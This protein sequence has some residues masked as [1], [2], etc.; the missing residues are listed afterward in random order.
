MAEALE[1]LSTGAFI[2]DNTSLA[3][4]KECPRKYYYGILQGYRPLS[5]APP[6]TFGK[7]YHDALETYDRSKA[8]GKSHD[9]SIADAI[10]VAYSSSDGDAT[11]T[12]DSRRSRNSLI[13]AIVWYAEQYQN[14]IMETIIL[15]N[16]KP[17]V[18]LSFRVELPFAFSSSDDPVFYCGHIDRVVK[19]NE[20]LYAC[21]HKHTVSAFYDSYWDR[22]TF[23]S[24]ISGYVMALKVD[25]QLEVAGALID[26]TQV[27]AT[28]A[29]FGRRIAHRVELHQQ[30]WITDLS[31][32]MSQLDLCIRSDRFPH[33]TE[34]CSKYGGCQFKEV[35]FAS[36]LVRDSIL[37]SHFK[38]EKW[39]PLKP[40]GEEE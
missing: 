31:Y 15:P 21:E 2:I 20:R 6:L 16:G 37:S 40:R 29:R 17:A 24:Q 33:N 19:Y 28:F 11:F 36:P 35:C 14:D 38:V 9:E 3:I 1:A 12:L 7:V 27:G 23:G 8:K 18:E 25:F 26:A 5:A 34:S 13:R 30:E 22:Y 39:N 10:R 4:F 32:W